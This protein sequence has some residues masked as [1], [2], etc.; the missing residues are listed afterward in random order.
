MSDSVEEVLK[1]AHTKQICMDL[2]QKKGNLV[3]DLKDLQEL[4]RNLPKYIID[5]L[6]RLIISSMY[7]LIASNEKRKENVKILISDVL[8]VLFNKIT[9]KQTTLFFN[10]YAYFLLE[11]FD[12]KKNRLGRFAGVL[13]VVYS[14]F[15]L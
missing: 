3:E 10:L 6:E 12:L 8:G 2:V 4:L 5:H 14:S 13:L 9:I 15:V 7:T 1:Y 11:I